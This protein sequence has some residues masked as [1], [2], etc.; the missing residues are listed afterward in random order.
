MSSTETA[1]EV[2]TVTNLTLPKKCQKKR[3]LSRAEKKLILNV[4]KKE[5]QS[6]PDPFMTN[7][8]NNTVSSTGTCRASVYRVIEEYKTKHELSSPNKQKPWTTVVKTTDDFDRN[9]IR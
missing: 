8:V 3:P 1:D 4:Y 7:V 6:N 5:V 2:E 9:A